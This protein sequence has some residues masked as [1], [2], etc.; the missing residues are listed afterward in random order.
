MCKGWIIHLI[1][2]N[3]IE[4]SIHIQ[5]DWRHCKECTNQINLYLLSFNIQQLKSLMQ[6]DFFNWSPLFSAKMIK[7]QRVNR[8]IWSID[9]FIWNFAEIVTIR[10]I[11][12]CLLSIYA[13]MKG[14]WWWSEWKNGQPKEWTYQWTNEWINQWT[15][16]GPLTANF[17]VGRGGESSPPTY[18]TQKVNNN[19]LK[20]CSS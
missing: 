16:E 9:Q 4:Q 20:L 6:G 15:R 14:I 19:Y 18:R 7:G 17:I 11:S 1:F 8:R 10:S 12:A 3:L 5:I 2:S 13:M